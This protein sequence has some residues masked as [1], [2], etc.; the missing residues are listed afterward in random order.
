MKKNKGFTLVE[1]LAVIVILAVILVIAIPNVMKIIDKARLDSY[2]RTEGMLVSAAQ[3]YMAQQGITLTAVG[4]TTTVSYNTDLRGNNFID[5][6]SDQASKNECTNSKVIVTKTITG[7]TYKPIMLCDNYISLDNVLT[8]A[9]TLVNEELVDVSPVNSIADGWTIAGSS[10][11]SFDL[12][13]KAQVFTPT[14]Q[15]GSLNYNFLSKPGWAIGDVIYAYGMLKV[16]STSVYFY[17]NDQI[18]QFGSFHK[19]DGNYQFMSARLQVAPRTPDRTSIS[20]KIQDNK[21]SGW[22]P[23]SMQRIVVINLTTLYGAGNEPSQAIM[24]VLINKSK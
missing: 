22:T 5:K 3:K 23:I 17:I 12:V 14:V 9:F 8:I 18:N 10:N 20:V 11:I 7:Y 24:D 4:D 21:A 1:L 15:Y 2:K 19:G 6:I 13:D 16:S